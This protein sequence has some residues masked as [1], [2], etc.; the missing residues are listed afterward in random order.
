MSGDLLE[1][2]Q[3]HPGRGH[4]RQSGVP[5][6]VPTQMLVAEVGYDLIPMAGIPQHAGSDPPSATAKCG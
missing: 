6:I 3:A 4:P 1:H 2:V 5:Q